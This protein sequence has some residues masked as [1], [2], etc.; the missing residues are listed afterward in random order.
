M[1]TKPSKKMTEKH[2][3]NMPIVSTTHLFITTDYF[4]KMRQLMDTTLAA[5]RKTI[6]SKSVWGE[7]IIYHIEN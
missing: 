1:T 2:I 5:G 4:D 7:V 3:K 6:E